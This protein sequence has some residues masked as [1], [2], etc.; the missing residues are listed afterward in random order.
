MTGQE[1]T[2]LDPAEVMAKH[3]SL[4]DECRSC[5]CAACGFMWPC[6]PYRLAAD[7]AAAREL[8]D[9]VRAVLRRGGTWPQIMDGLHAALAGEGAAE[10][11]CTGCKAETGRWIRHQRGCPVER[12]EEEAAEGAAD[13]PQGEP[14]RVRLGCGWG[15]CDTSVDVQG[16]DPIGVLTGWT[17]D[18]RSWTCPNHGDYR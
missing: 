18:G 1:Q 5:T 14:T 8:E 11:S 9:Q 12:A 2:P 4:H 6:V 7:L 3:G 16:G 13:Q 10:Q 15:N 17:F